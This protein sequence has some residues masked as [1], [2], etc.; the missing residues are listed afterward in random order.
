[1]TFNFPQC[2]LCRDVSK[3]LH[4]TQVPENWKHLIENVLGN[5]DTLWHVSACCCSMGEMTL[6]SVRYQTDSV[7]YVTLN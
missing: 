2:L 6:K 4:S 7:V 5:R 1:M 3:E